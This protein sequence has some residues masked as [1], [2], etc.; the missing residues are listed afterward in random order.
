MAIEKTL[1]LVKPDGVERGLVGE[2]LGRFERMGLTIEAMNLL[3]PTRELADAHYP[4]DDG[5][6]SAVGNKT[7]EDYAARGFDA[8]LELGTSDPIAVGR[9]IKARLTTFLTSGK[10]VALVLEGNRAVESVRKVVGATLPTASPMGTI[11]GDFS[12]DSPD[13]AAAEGRPVKNLVHASGNVEEA[14]AEIELWF[15]R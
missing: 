5:W 4:S 1:V 7:L 6:L 2:I 11:R 10:V 12:T 15:G 9:Q 3:I 8:S 14:V 13:A